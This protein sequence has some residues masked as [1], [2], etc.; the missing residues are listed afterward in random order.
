MRD[1]PYLSV[2]VVLGLILILIYVVRGLRHGPPYPDLGR[3]FVLFVT[4]NG[5]PAGVKLI[6]IACFG[7]DLGDFEG[8]VDWMYVVAG[9]LGAIWVSVLE[10]TNVLGVRPYILRLFRGRAR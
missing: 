10:I 7:K 2:G 4:A 5:I 9:G 6:V 1:D 8:A 3:A